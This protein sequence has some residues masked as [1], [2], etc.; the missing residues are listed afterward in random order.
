MT[1]KV[2][3]KL[4][5]AAKE[6]RQEVFGQEQG[7]KKEFDEI[8]PIA[9]HI[10]LLEDDDPVA[11]CRFYYSKERE[12]YIVGRIAVRKE[13]RGKRYGEKVL[14]GAEEEI[15]KAGGKRIELSAQCRVSQF[16]LKQG[17]TDTKDV[18][19]DE[20][21]PHTWMRKELDPACILNEKGK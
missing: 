19:M 17:Y 10:I 20:Y 15:K 4:P 21:C 14:Q 7:F 5:R 11:T 6:I 12:C 13:A 9:K 2:Y 18:H 8:D 3:D 1:I 16:Y